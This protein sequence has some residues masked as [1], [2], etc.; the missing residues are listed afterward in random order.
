MIDEHL[1]QKANKRWLQIKHLN[2]AMGWKMCCHY[3]SCEF[4]TMAQIAHLWTTVCLLIWIY[5]FVRQ[6]LSLPWYS[7]RQVWFTLAHELTI[8]VWYNPRVSHSVI[9]HDSL[10]NITVKGKGISNEFIRNVLRWCLSHL[11]LNVCSIVR[12]MPFTFMWQNYNKACV[13][14]AH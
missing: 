2:I 6:R 14:R 13:S 12:V 8:D 3:I 9:W 4:N 11:L 1:S 10:H 5:Q 7:T